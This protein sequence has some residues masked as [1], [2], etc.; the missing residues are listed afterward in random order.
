MMS[1][2][3]VFLS[4]RERSTV[5]GILREFACRIGRVNV[6]GSRATGGAHAGSDLDLVVFPPS[7][8][9][10]IAKLRF[11]FEDSDLPIT[12]DVLAW[13]DIDHQ[14]LRDAIARHSIP[15]FKEMA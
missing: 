11:A 9:N 13:D 8:R 6:F 14:P 2:D 7:P 4:D 15:F 10:E 3:R 1:D 12:V 5:S